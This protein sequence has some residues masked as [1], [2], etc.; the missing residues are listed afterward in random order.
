MM[1]SFDKAALGFI[2]HADAA[3]SIRKQNFTWPCTIY[4]CNAQ[5]ILSFI[6]PKT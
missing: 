5:G 4:T 3:T 1:P 6:I 2:Q